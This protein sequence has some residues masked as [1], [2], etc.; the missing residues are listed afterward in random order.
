LFSDY[1]AFRCCFRSCRGQRLVG[2]PFDRNGTEAAAARRTS[3][4]LA[5][6]IGA[7]SEDRWAEA[8]FTG[9]RFMGTDRST[10]LARAN[11]G[12]T[13]RARANAETAQRSPRSMARHGFLAKLTASSRDGE[14]QVGTLL[15]MSY[16]TAPSVLDLAPRR[17][18][19]GTSTALADNDFQAFVKSDIRGIGPQQ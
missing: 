9:A 19:R 2:V 3:V 13:A 10:S 17:L 7:I 12:H 18:E 4:A 8:A 16:F 14:N 1:P 6:E 5:V 15:E 11:S